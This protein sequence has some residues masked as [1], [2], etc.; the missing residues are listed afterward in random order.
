MTPDPFRI[1]FLTLSLDSQAVLTVVGLVLGAFVFRL[2]ARR[3]ALDL[4][5]GHWWDLVTVSVVGARLLWVATHADYYLRQP[6]QVV[7]IVDGGLHPLGLAL[8]AVY[9]IWRLG[10]LGDGPGESASWRLVA[11]L[12]AVG[13]LTTFLFERAGC[14]LMTCGA[15]PSSAM[16]WALQRGSEWREPVALEQV[17][18]LAIALAVSVELLRVRGAAFFTGLVAL[19]LV[20]LIAFTAETFAPQ[21]VVAL[22]MMLLIYVVTWL[23]STPRDVPG[24]RR[25]LGPA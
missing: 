13:T 8:G 24:V 20:E 15:G 1:Q 21:E 16:P 5:A 3:L 4:G 2:A 23:R 22:G 19:T 7:V 25:R 11:D 6:L 18:V 9:W 17:V 14:A 10:R 12:V